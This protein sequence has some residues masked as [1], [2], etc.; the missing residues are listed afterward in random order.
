MD[1]DLGC[2]ESFL[3]LME[4]AHYGRAAQRLHLTV[5]ALS[6]RIARLEHQVGVPLLTRDTSGVAGP[7]EAGRRFA[8]HAAPLLAAAHSARAAA[9]ASPAALTLRLGVLGRIGDQPSRYSLIRTAEQL[10]RH[11]PGVRLL[12]RS[13]PISAVY[14]CLLERAVDV[15]W[16]AVEDAPSG[17]LLHPLVS[18]DR[19]GIVSASHPLAEAPQVHAG[20]FGELPLLCNPAVPAAWMAPFLLNDT[21]APGDARLVEINAED[22][23]RVYECVARG[24]GVAIATH[25]QHSPPINSGLRTVR[26]VGL[27]PVSFFSACRRTDRRA[28]V[29]T[30][31]GILLQVAAEEAADLTEPPLLMAAQ[32]QRPSKLLGRHPQTP[33]SAAVAAHMPA[34]QRRDA[35]EAEAEN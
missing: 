30:L 28:P 24:K 16:G 18:G 21:R 31:L 27:S 10:R 3:I 11:H 23:A 13:L 32:P 25:L 1:L 14:S 5:S 19:F 4:E 29:R 22:A 17:V 2:V 15:V 20:E 12:C 7:T 8:A 26:L 6:K 34:S 33:T 9:R 35:A